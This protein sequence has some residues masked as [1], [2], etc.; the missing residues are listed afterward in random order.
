MKKLAITLTLILFLVALLV[1][2]I[3]DKYKDK[4]KED[5]LKD[6]GKNATVTV[7]KETKLKT[8]EGKDSGITQVDLTV[9]NQKITMFTAK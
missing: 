4:A 7:D 3:D 9:D 5:V 8:K 6:L 1:L 2:A